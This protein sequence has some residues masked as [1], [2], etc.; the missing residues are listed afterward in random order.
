MMP[1]SGS[2]FGL[3]CAV[4]TPPAAASADPSAKVNAMTKS[5]L[6]P[7]SFAELMLN[8]TARIALPTLVLKMM[9]CSSTISAIETTKM[10]ICDVEMVALPKSV[11]FS[12]GK[13]WGNERGVP[14]KKK[15]KRY[16]ISSDIP[17]AVISV[18]IFEYFRTGRYAKRSI[19]IP[20]AAA[21]AI[22]PNSVTTN[23]NA[24]GSE[25]KPSATASMKPA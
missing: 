3:Y 21:I 22:A 15:T 18:V 16:S 25:A 14:E 10:S 5:V 24:D 2:I 1:I 9:Y 20:I 11:M 6:I 4:R 8:E 19:A 7:I 12:F 23:P 17:I 13:S